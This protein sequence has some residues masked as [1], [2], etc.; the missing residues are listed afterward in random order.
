MA[1]LKEFSIGMLIIGKMACFFDNT[2]INLNKNRRETVNLSYLSNMREF[3]SPDIFLAECVEDYVVNAQNIQ[4]PWYKQPFEKGSARI[5]IRNVSLSRIV[6]N[7]II[8]PYLFDMEDSSGKTEVFWHPVFAIASRDDGFRSGAPLK[9]VS[10]R[11]AFFDGSSKV[12]KVVSKGQ[13][14]RNDRLRNRSKSL[15]LT[16]RLLPL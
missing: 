11:Y 3:F 9:E 14:R 1:C 16:G 6:R 8:Q 5:L 2:M 15:D 4:I 13:P 10:L 12:E 7:G